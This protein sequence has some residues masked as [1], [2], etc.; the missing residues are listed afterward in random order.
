MASA[1]QID[2]THLFDSEAA[3]KG[4]ALNEMCYSFNDARN[5]QAFL[6]DEEAYCA[7]FALTPEQKNAVAQRNVLAMMAAGGNI[8]YLAKLAGIF[9]LNV[10]FP[11]S[12]NG[13]DLRL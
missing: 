8:Y 7:R 1:P 12:T 13:T 4:L 5:R 6:D 9:G 2:G 11:V 10:L 3:L